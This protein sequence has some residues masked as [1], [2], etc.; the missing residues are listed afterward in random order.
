MSYTKKDKILY[1]LILPNLKDKENSN[2]NGGNNLGVLYTVKHQGEDYD[3]ESFKELTE[4]IILNFEPGTYD[5][6]KVD[7]N[8]KK[9]F[10]ASFSFSKEEKAKLI[11]TLPYNPED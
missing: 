5:I 7:K 11:Q 4:Y 6:Y 8:G 2:N 3:S 10:Y 9:T 1:Y